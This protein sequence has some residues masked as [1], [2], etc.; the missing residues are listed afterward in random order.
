MLILFCFCPFVFLISPACEH[1]EVEDQHTA[2]GVCSISDEEQEEEQ[3]YRGDD[4]YG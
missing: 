3:E 1:D 2:G 4:E